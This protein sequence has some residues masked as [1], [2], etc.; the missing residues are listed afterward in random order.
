MFGIVK[1]IDIFIPDIPESTQLRIDIDEMI[2]AEV[3]GDDS[4][5]TKVKQNPRVYR[6]AGHEA[7][8]KG[9]VWGSAP[10]HPSLD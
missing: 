10:I 6:T 4:G 3:L 5:N 1:C 7:M 8:H 2:A 9:R